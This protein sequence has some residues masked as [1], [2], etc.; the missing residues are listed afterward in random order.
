MVCMPTKPASIFN[1]LSTLKLSKYEQLCNDK[2]WE[3]VDLTQMYEPNTLSFPSTK[4]VVKPDQIDPDIG[5]NNF[6]HVLLAFEQH[7][8]S[9]MYSVLRYDLPG[10]AGLEEGIRV[11]PELLGQ[12]LRNDAIAKMH[13]NIFGITAQRLASYLYSEGEVDYSIY[14]NDWEK[15][16]SQFDEKDIFKL[17]DKLFPDID[18]DNVV[19]DPM[20]SIENVIIKLKKIHSKI[21]QLPE[22]ERRIVAAKTAVAY[23]SQMV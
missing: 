3:W 9:V 7:F 21:V 1:K 11:T 22:V 10:Q 8:W 16:V 13:F 20:E 15:I 17:T 12:W 2:N 19:E 5:L 4:L 23:S 14:D 18:S 6:L